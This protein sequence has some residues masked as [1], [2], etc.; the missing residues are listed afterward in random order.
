MASGKNVE[1]IIDKITNT[2]FNGKV[3]KTQPLA[4]IFTKKNDTYF[5]L[6]VT[7]ARL[8]GARR[9]ITPNYEI[10]HVSIYEAL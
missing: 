7:I 8:L 9:P 5:V 4:S 3:H 2:I 6:V 1:I 10:E